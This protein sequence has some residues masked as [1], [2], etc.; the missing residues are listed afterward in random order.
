MSDKVESTGNAV[1]WGVRLPLILFA[2]V[3]G[4]FFLKLVFGK[5]GEHVLNSVLIGKPVP[6]F[7]LPPVTG[8][9][10]KKGQPV[11]GFSGKTLRSSGKYTI[12]N[13][14]ASWCVS[15]RYEHKYLEELAK[16]SGAQIYGFNFKDTASGARSF[17]RKYGN[18]YAAIGMATGRDG[19]ELGIHRVPETFVINDKGVIVYKY[20][21]PVSMKVIH[22][23]ILPAIA[24]AKAKDQ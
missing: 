16:A 9:L 3:G 23:L 8:L 12:L 24:R 14:W 6:E 7:V 2:I 15:C 10:D 11:P 19:I 18:P 5:G 4:I 17:L 20:P 21:G 22:Q 13:V 1:R